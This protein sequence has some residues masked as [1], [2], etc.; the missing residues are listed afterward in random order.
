MKLGTKISLILILNLVLATPTSSVPVTEQM[1]VKVL[2]PK[3]YA[4]HKATKVYKWGKSQQKC[5]RALWGKESAWNYQAKS[6]TKDYGIPQRHMSKNSIE[7][8]KDFLQHPNRQID[9]GLNYIQVR[10]GSP[11]AAW[12]FHLKNNWY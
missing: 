7:E 10:Y 6:P 9:W 11:C 4:A 2:E 3:E 1:R 5:L 12:K 8:I